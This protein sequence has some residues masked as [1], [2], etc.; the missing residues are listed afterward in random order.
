MS[1]TEKEKQ[2]KPKVDKAKLAESIKQKDKVIN[3]NQTVKK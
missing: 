2:D 1:Q 3:N